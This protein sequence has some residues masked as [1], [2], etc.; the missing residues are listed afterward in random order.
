MISAGGVH[1][2][3]DE[4][5]FETIADEKTMLGSGQYLFRL[6]KRKFIRIEI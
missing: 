5:N 6:G 2:M 3:I 1:K 4:S